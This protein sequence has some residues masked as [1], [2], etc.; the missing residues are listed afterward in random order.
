[1]SK[2]Y[3]NLCPVDHEDKRLSSTGTNLVAAD[4][5]Q[6]QFNDNDAILRLAL[7]LTMYEVYGAFLVT[8]IELQ[9]ILSFARM[10]RI[11]LS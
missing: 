4:L 11:S 1:M 3:L 6:E 5:F 9:S 7:T 10:G 8:E 2:Q